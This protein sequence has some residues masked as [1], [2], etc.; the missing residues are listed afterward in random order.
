MSN[1]DI[2]RTI[3]QGGVEIDGQKITDPLSVVSGSELK[4]GKSIRRRL[5]T[6]D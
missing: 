2:K 5:V 3:E 6:G 4:F 1:S